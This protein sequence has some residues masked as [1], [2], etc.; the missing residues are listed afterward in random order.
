MAVTGRN[1]TVANPGIGLNHTSDAAAAPRSGACRGAVTW[2]M[3]K[4]M[5]NVSCAIGL[6]LLLLR[7]GFAPGQEPDKKVPPPV[8]A[9]R[10]APVY[11]IYSTVMA[12]PK[13]SHPDDN[14]KYLIVET[15]GVG[16]ETDPSACAALP[17]GY[18]EAFAEL[19]KD[20]D[21]HRKDRS[22]LERAFSIDKPYELIS[23][24]QARDFVATRNGRVLTGAQASLFRGAVDLIRLGNV[25]FDRNR[26]V[27]AVY[28][29]AWCGGL[30]GLWTWRLF[31][32]NGKGD[33]DEQPWTRCVTVAAARSIRSSEPQR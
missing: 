22:Q 25:Y 29:S 5:T 3:D 17:D 4:M 28:T 20:R 18:R 23:E 12:H 32:S 11:A 31:T 14:K 13:L 1:L 27:A 24:A 7:P 26:T 19:L 30:C 15:S 21:E 8:P 10:R 6:S 16:Q 9:E 2:V 33:W